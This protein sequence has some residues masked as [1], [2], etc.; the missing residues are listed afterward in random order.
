MMISATTPS[1]SAATLPQNRRTVDLAAIRRNV[2]RIRTASGVKLMAVVKADAFGHGAVEVARTVLSAG[3]EWLGVATIEEALEL[4]A[5]DIPAPILC[6]LI[7][8]LC[9]LEDAVRAGVT[10][11]CANG[12]TVRAVVLAATTTGLTA[13]IHLELDTGMA[14]GGAAPD[15][16]RALCGDAAEDGNQLPGR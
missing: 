11:S 4:R 10:L 15:E 7:D 6:W 8:P 1:V 9:A 14:R 12:E 13:D 16:W 2:E 5:A 3:A